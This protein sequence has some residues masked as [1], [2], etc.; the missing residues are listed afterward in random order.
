MTRPENYAR[1]ATQAVH[2]SRT[3]DEL[4][5]LG[6]TEEQAERV[7]EWHRDAVWQEVQQAGG[8]VVSR[9]L[10]FI[11]GR[12]G[13]SR[14]ANARLRSL[15]VAFAAGLNGLTGASSMTEAAKREG[16]SPRALSLVAA[17]AA[18]YLGLPTG[19]N[20]RNG[21]PGKESFKA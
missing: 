10:G 9:L 7:L 11:L 3:L 2:T 19:P 18:Q 8:V 16:C 12:P 17:E 1:F 21:A 5:D 13:E 6:L 15:G 4:A 20:R 14:V